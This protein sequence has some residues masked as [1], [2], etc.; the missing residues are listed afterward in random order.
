MRIAEAAIG[1]RLAEHDGEFFAALLQDSM[2][3]VDK[4][5]ADAPALMVWIDRSA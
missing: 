4:G 5:C 2:G 1:G 3:S